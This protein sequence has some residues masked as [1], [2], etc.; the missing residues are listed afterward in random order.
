MRINIFH[1]PICVLCVVTVVTVESC[2]MGVTQHTQGSVGV[3]QGVIISAE[4][5]DNTEVLDEAFQ[6]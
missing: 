1:V 2:W 6:T 4:Y 5:S 3:L